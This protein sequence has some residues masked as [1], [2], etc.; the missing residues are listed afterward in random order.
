M[1]WSRLLYPLFAI[2]VGLCSAVN[3]HVKRGSEQNATLY[4]YGANSSAWPIAY[5]VNDG[6]CSLYLDNPTYLFFSH[7][8]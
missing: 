4:A 6:M 8:H 3:D 5:G 1:Q 2:H 7:G